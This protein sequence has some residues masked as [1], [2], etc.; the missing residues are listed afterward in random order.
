MAQI[1]WDSYDDVQTYKIV[2][3]TPTHWLA[4]PIGDTRLN[5]LP[6]SNY[7]P[8]KQRIQPEPNE[9]GYT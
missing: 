5:A 6:K 1:D 8:V 2:G 9:I 3:E 7:E 4:V